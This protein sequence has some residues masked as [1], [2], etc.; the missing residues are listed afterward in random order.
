MNVYINHINVLMKL[1]QNTFIL[2]RLFKFL[3]VFALVLGLVY[4]VV[5]G[6][7]M[8]VFRSVFT[9]QE[10]LADGS[11]WVEKTFSLSGLVD[12]IQVHPELV[13]VTLSDTSSVISPDSV[14]I[15]FESDRPR[16]MAG[17][18]H[19]ILLAAYARLVENGELDPAQI[20]TKD[21]INRFLVPGFEPSK[22]RE[23]LR[24][25]AEISSSES[26]FTLDSVVQAVILRNHQPSADLL[27]SL[28]GTA[29]LDA[30]LSAS[31]LFGIERPSLWSAFHIAYATKGASEGYEAEY[32]L[33]A[34]RLL[35][36]D[37]TEAGILLKAAG[38]DQINYS[39]NDEKQA[40]SVL[41]KAIPGS[42]AAFMVW[43]LDESRFGT[44]ATQITKKQL[45]WP[46]RDTKVAR[47]FTAL[48]AIYDNRI[49]ISHGVAVGTSAYTHRTQVSTV[50]F[51]QLPVGF[52]MH[53]SSNLINQDY[54][55]RL[56]YD[57]ALYERSFNMLQLGQ[58]STSQPETN[59]G[60]LPL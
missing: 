29:N 41:P 31:E 38:I 60:E 9:N 8:N 39:F 50:Y 44:R 57:P 45:G 12:F 55:M 1:H 59:P 51:D 34:G 36:D 33:L 54:Q 14:A 40:Y 49:S 42:M 58:T 53:M 20:V 5:I 30:T 17:T 10:A 25:Y 7:N 47:D 19:L 6:L 21:Q 52:W 26:E 4:I 18:G 32:D 28:I 37:T 13:S 48:Y 27:Y 11:E 43:I 2:M 56:M 15:G 3:S 46:M 35:S 23:T 16:V 24:L 22:H